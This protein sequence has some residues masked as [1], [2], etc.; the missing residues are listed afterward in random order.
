MENKIETI[1]VLVPVFNG[2]KYIAKCL[3]SLINQTYKN[4]RIV[5]ANDGSTDSTSLILESYQKKYSNIVVA[6]KQ[7]EKNISKTRNFLLEQIKSKY[8]TFF[9][10]DDYAEPT[11]IEELYT[12]MI[13]YGCDMSLCDK[14]RHN[15]NKNVNLSKF[16][17]N[18]KLYFMNKQEAIAEMLS[19]NLFNGTTYAKLMKTKTLKDARFDSDIHYGEDLDFC[20]KIMQ[21][22]N[23]YVLTTKKLYHY[24]IRKGSIVTSKF[25]VSKVTCVD[26]YDKIINKVKDNEELFVCAKSMQGLIAIEILYYTWRDKYKDKQLKKRL[27][28][29]I[30]ASIPFIKKNKRLSKLLKCTPAVWR[31]TKIMWF[32][33]F[34]FFEL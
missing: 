10:S 9:D 28:E 4:L 30:K 26:C 12:I 23:S 20:F 14:L 19:S 2:E 29:T 34:L 3:D 21:N 27:K 7:N 16:N 8:F 32:I 11:Y 17:K 1:D 25:K 33:I 5:V 31:L 6:Y 13:N 15:E 22:C 18:P 24:I